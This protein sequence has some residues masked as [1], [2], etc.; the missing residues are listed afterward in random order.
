MYRLRRTLVA[1]TA[2][3]LLT[4]PAL[5][6]EPLRGTPKARFHLFLLIGQSNMAGRGVIGEQ[7][8]NGYS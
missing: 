8:N 2:A 7:D 6:A 5:S 3:L 4:S 1:F